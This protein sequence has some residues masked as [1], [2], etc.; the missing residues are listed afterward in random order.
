M[1]GWNQPGRGAHSGSNRP[2]SIKR[3]LVLLLLMGISVFGAIRLMGYAVEYL[4]S[5]R[6]SREMRYAYLTVTPTPLPTE[7]PIPTTTPQLDETPLVIVCTPVAATPMPTAVQSQTPCPYPNNPK[8]IVNDRFKSLRSINRDMIGW[9][10]IDHLLDEAVVQRNNVFYLDHDVKGEPN[11]NGAI[12]LDAM[13]SLRSRPG[14]L[15][16]YGHNMKSGAM[17]GSLRNYE[18][19]DFYHRA[20][21]IQMDT[22]YEDGEYVVFAVGTIS[23]NSMD[24]AYVDLYAIQGWRAEEKERAIRA[25][26]QQSIYQST[27]EV[28]PEDQLLLLVT[29]VDRADQ[30]RVVAARRIRD[31][32]SKD[33]LTAQ[34]NRSQRRR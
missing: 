25:L 27:I 34:V 13:T 7:V 3:E 10:H 33:A 15:I 32:E 31:Q 16:L 23:V 21:F 11:S 29:C 19:A 6:T 4:R 20:P 22:L 2:L 30:R 24:A 17:F 5:R 18:N 28:L 14:A 12:F 9:L 8:L 1:K 26:Q